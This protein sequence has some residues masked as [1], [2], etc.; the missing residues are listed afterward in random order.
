MV[1]V[2]L[3]TSNLNKLREIKEILRDLPALSFLSLRAFPHYTPP[4][5]TGVTFE[6]NAILKSVT[7]AKELHHWVLAEDSGLVVPA[8]EGRPGIYS[9]RYAGKEG[10]E[11]SDKENRGKLLEEM[12]E[13][14]GVA[15][16]A[17]FVCSVALSSPA[18]LVACESATCEGVV[19]EQEKGSGGF[20]Y[21]P[22]FRKHDYHLTF[23]ELDEATKN[24]VSHR[25]KALELIRPFL[26]RLS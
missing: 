4:E 6:E 7:A 5:E 18:G 23:A 19:V 1:E 12:R 3:A 11:A 8:L 22:L 25:R 10:K 17:Y 2:V 20:G 24:R 26:E 14:S 21:D 9:A 13:L 15:R 16:S